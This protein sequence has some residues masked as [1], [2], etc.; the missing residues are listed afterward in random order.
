MME[1]THLSLFSGIGGFDL[2][3]E[4]AGFRTIGLVEKNPY[5]QRVLRKYW[6]DVPL[7]GDI[8][9][10]TEESLKE[11]RIVAN[12][13]LNEWNESRKGRRPRGLARK[14]RAEGKAGDKPTFTS[15]CGSQNAGRESGTI[16]P[17]TLITGGVPCSRTWPEMFRVI[18]LV[19][20]HWVLAENVAGIVRM[21]LDTVLSDLEGEGY[22]VQAFNIP[23]CGTNAPHRRERIWIVGSLSSIIQRRSEYQIVGRGKARAETGGGGEDVAKSGCKGLQDIQRSSQA[24]ILAGGPPACNGSWWNSEP[25]LGRVAY[26]IPSRVDRLAAL[27]DAIVPQVAYQ[28]LKAIA[29]I[30]VL[31]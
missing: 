10:V 16:S 8:R 5:R 24:T 4:W 26:G 14:E 25:E 11:K 28:I 30:E 6:P 18:Q 9:D 31:R 17:V 27:G 21:A 3:A 13:Q 7:W 23:A 1:L 15:Q 19:R 12:T 29:E 2:A 20:P 22:S